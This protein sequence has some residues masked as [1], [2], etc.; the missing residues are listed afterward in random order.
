LVILPMRLAA[1]IAAVAEGHKASQKAKRSS[2][3]GRSRSAKGERR[4]G[5]GAPFGC[6]Q[7][8]PTSPDAA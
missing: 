3:A 7:G 4:D 2:L 5:P 6:Y 8:R 1:E